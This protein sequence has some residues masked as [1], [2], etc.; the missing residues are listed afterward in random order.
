MQ[1]GEQTMEKMMAHANHAWD[2]AMHSLF[3]ALYFIG[4]ETIPF[5]K[6]RG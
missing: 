4:K 6:F 2:E 3:Q 1:K 5:S